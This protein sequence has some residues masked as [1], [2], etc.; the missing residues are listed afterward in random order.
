M[1][2]NKMHNSIVAIFSFIQKGILAYLIKQFLSI[3]PMVLTTGP[4]P[5]SGDMVSIAGAFC[6]MVMD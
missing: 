5:F 6:S 4:E 1:V 3:R 2:T